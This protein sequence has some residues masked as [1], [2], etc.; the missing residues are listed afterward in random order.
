MSEVEWFGGEERSFPPALGGNQNQVLS[1]KRL[2]I[3]MTVMTLH[4]YNVSE[5]HGP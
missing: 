1:L 2:H 4:D 5:G 3:A